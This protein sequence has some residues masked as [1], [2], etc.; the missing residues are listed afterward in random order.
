M[1]LRAVLVVFVAAGLPLHGAAPHCLGPSV[2]A[3][4][5]KSIAAIQVKTAMARTWVNAS[6]L[7]L[8][9]DARN[10]EGPPPSISYEIRRAK[11]GLFYSTNIPGRQ[12]VTLPIQIV[13]GGERHGLGFLVRIGQIGGIPLERAA[14]VQAR[15]FWSFHR[16]SLVLAPGLSAEKPHS[17]QA[18]LGVV[19]SPDF[20]KRCLTCHGAPRTLGAGQQG[21]V[22]CESCHGP[23]SEHLLAIAKGNPREGII[24]PAVLSPGASIA[25]CA[26][27]HAGF[28][29]HIDPAP[30]DL[31][32][33]NQVTALRSSECF[34]QS[35]KQIS[36]TTCHDPHQD[37]Q[38]DNAATERACLSCHSVSAN[39]H[40]AI[41]PVNRGSGC[42]GCH[43]PTVEVGPLHLVDHLIRV[44]PEQGVTAPPH[45]DD[46]RSEVRPV[47]EY[48]RS[49]A[50]NSRSRAQKTEARLAQGESFY[51]VARES[52]IDP[53]A[54]I[55][56]YLGPEYLSNLDPVLAA[57]AAAL[58]YGGISGLVKDGN[59]WVILQRLPRDFKWDA[60]RL[61]GE[62]NTLLLKGDSAGAIRKAQQAL[63]LYP[64]FLRALAFIGTVYAENESFERAA[65]I[66]RVATKLYP[67]DANSLFNLGLMLEQLN[68][69]ND[70][71]Q[72]YQLAIQA[73]P[74]FVAAYAKLG[75]ALYSAGRFQSAAE[76]F[77]QGLEIDPLSADLYYNL[78]L[79]LNQA[80]DDQAAGHAFALA[81]KINPSL[82]H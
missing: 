40:L 76:L 32:I 54:P 3:G 8:D 45:R 33:A 79:A 43:M 77:R 23:G 14:F 48:L 24:N 72:T 6:S 71:I 18:A 66:F 13:M 81:A 75:M 11:Q 7:P 38:L 29:N 52:S 1:G 25:I 73:E 2:C 74:D 70:A 21:G 42:I 68:R 41:C 55:G 65:E 4:C 51:V 44:H 67:G 62:A 36:C 58:P 10:L 46:L 15:Y 16:N 34:I 37:A 80:G 59:R 78:S 5:H 47:R 61:L 57:A 69:R 82:A 60:G 28:G 53:A 39:T 26:Q 49:I 20:E 35:G 50:L 19:L 30:A 27:C 63:M 17:F 9:Y 12:R 31:L 56:G 64:H 22:H